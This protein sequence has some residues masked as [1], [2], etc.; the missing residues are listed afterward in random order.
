MINYIEKIIE[1][2]KTSIF[3]YALSLFLLIILYVSLYPSLSKAS[4]VYIKLIK[5][6]PSAFKS[7]FGFS[8]LLNFTLLN[9]LSTEYLSLLFLVILIFFTISFASSQISGEI[10]N[11][12][13]GVVLSLPISR[14]KIYLSK[15]IV[16]VIGTMILV[17]FGVISI[18]P[19]AAMM[20]IR[21]SA[22]SVY[23]ISMM[24]FL[25]SLSSLSIGFFIS[26]V[27]SKKG[28]SNTLSA[29]IFLVMYIANI[30]SSINTHL[31][32]L[33]Y[34]SFFY[35]Y[36]IDNIIKY[37]HIRYLS[38]SVFLDVFIFFSLLGMFIFYKRDIEL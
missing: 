9:F 38:I 8:N 1:K 6:M 12:T 14:I 3:W 33:R 26:S 13:I 10:E 19:I 37:N 21:V 35:Y 34:I 36:N 15:Y 11:K 2:R 30:I 28:L 25:F 16:G 17:I 24:A 31:K 5:S 7:A 29:I 22:E 4:G 32:F 20:N 27:F 23:L 18:V